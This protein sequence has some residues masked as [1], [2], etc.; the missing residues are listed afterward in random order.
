MIPRAVRRFHERG[1]ITSDGMRISERVEK[2]LEN[3]RYRRRLKGRNMFS[4]N[5]GKYVEGFTFRITLVI[6]LY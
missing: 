1:F 4:N 6:Q 3:K 2:S 5:R